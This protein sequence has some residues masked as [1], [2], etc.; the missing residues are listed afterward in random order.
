MSRLGGWHGTL[1]YRHRTS[2]QERGRENFALP[3]NLDGSRSLRSPLYPLPI[4]GTVIRHLEAMREG[5]DD[6]ERRNRE[7]RSSMDK[8]MPAARRRRDL[9]KCP[10]RCF[11]VGALPRLDEAPGL[12]KSRGTPARHHRA[13]R[14]G[15]RRPPSAT[16]AAARA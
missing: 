2:G 11:V 5:A 6:M 16:S 4:S 12:G 1:V 14:P 15:R 3:C 10:C 8:A 9:M 13:A 7:I